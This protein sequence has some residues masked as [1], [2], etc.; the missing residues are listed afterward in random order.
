MNKN[1]KVL[2]IIPA[3]GGSKRLPHKNILDLNGKPLIAWT[4]EAAKQSKFIDKL[5]VSTD[6]DKIAEISMQYGAEVPFI[7]PK[8]LASDTA[9]SLDV[10]LHAIH[11]FKEK[12]VQFDYVLL[13]QPTSPLRTNED[14]DN[15]F[16]LLNDKTK[17]VVSVCETEH[18]PLWSNTLPADLSMKD[19]IKPEIRNMRSQDLPKYYRLN[20]AVYISDINYMIQNDG[21]IGDNTKAFIMPIQRSIDVDYKTDFVMCKLLMKE[22]E[23]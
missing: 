12:E 2:A 16:N 7:R 13:L 21:F 15:A 10:V 6:D 19:F 8:N 3:R 11:F 14:I 5:I 22:N 18:S 9:S 20:G 23:I 17:A 4:I 1:K